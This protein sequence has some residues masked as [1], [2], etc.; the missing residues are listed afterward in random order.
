MQ[1]PIFERDELER[2]FKSV[3]KCLKDDGIFVFDVEDKSL[4]R[5]LVRQVYTKMFK[6]TGFKTYQHDLE[7][8]TKILKRAGFEV[9]DFKY[10]DHRVGRQLVLK[11]KKK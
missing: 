7:S 11:A 3:R 6:V 9:I 2:F 4:L 5:N 10:F 8:I 1:A